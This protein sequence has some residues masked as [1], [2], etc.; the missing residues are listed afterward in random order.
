MTNFCNG[1]ELVK[2]LET[3]KTDL[4]K[5]AVEKK[6]PYLKKGTYYHYYTDFEAMQEQQQKIVGS[7]CKVVSLG[8]HKGGVYKTTTAN[9]M[10]TIMAFLNYKVLLVELDIQCNLT[11]LYQKANNEN[12]II[13]KLKDNKNMGV[14]NIDLDIFQYGKLDFIPNDISLYKNYANFDYKDLDR[15]L[16]NYKKDYDFIILDTPPNL[17][18]TTPQA[19]KVRNIGVR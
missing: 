14:C 19:L 1:V 18:D 6:V 2:L 7:G 5:K 13:A 10:A 8:N 11:E 4:R 16:N 9:N 15:V 12:S 3:K 17:M